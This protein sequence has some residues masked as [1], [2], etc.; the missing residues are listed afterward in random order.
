MA[1]HLGLQQGTAL[2]MAVALLALA[3]A[4]PAVSAAQGRAFGTPQLSRRALQQ[5]SATSSIESG[6]VQAA[7][8]PKPLPGETL[9]QGFGTAD[10]PAETVSISLIVK[11][12]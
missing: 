12:R 7:A 9:P 8:T 3:V 10:L 2:M 11:G 4:A 1:S 5:A 6:N